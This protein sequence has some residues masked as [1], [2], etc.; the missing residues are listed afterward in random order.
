M[1]IILTVN[2]CNVYTYSDDNDVTINDDA[3]SDVAINDVTANDV[4]INV[5]AVNDATDI[6]ATRN[7]AVEDDNITNDDIPQQDQ[8]SHDLE[9]GSRDCNHVLDVHTDS[10][11]QSSKQKHSVNGFSYRRLLEQEEM[12]D[13]KLS[14]IV[15]EDL[16]VET[17][18]VIVQHKIGK[19]SYF[20]LKLK[21]V[22]DHA[23]STFL[24]LLS[25]LK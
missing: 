20:I 10:S 4:T 12:E 11:K 2:Y 18:D 6:D 7:L 17:S 8:S 5:V 25:L 9:A 21:L 22:K 14:T 13:N 23:I 1:Y 3:V 19:L 16:T 15:M 24:I